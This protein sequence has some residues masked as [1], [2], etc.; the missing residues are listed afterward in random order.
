MCK[1]VSLNNCPMGTTGAGP[2]LMLEVA[3]GDGSG[4]SVTVKVTGGEAITWLGTGLPAGASR[5]AIALPVLH[6]ATNMAPA[7]STAAAREARS[8]L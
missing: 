3:V 7:R 2:M 5:V 8:Q 4:V 1:E 6:A